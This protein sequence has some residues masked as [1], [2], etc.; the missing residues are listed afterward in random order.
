MR[1]HHDGSAPR[2]AVADARQRRA[3][4]RVV[5]DRAVIVLRHVEVGADEHALAVDVDI[6]EAQKRHRDQ[7][8]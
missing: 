4:A 1:C 8:S 2:D 6:A 5:G 7:I 3:D